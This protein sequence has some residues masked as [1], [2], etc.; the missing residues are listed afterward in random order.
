[1]IYLDTFSVNL[2]LQKEMCTYLVPNKKLRKYIMT[3]QIFK[4]EKLFHFA[5]IAILFI[6]SLNVH[7]QSWG[8]RGDAKTKV[9]VA[10]LKYQA[11]E[12]NLEAVGT[13]EAR[14]SVILF[15][16]V[17]ERVTLVDFE[18]G[19]FVEKDK[20]L[21]TLYNEREKV[22]LQRAKIQLKDTQR[23]YQRLVESRKKGAAS[24]SQVDVAQTAMALAEVAVKEADVALSERIVKAPFSGILGFTDVEVGD[25]ISQQT[26]ITT[27]DD[28]NELYIN[29]SAPEVA[30][31]ILNN[32]A[33]VFL[34]PWQDREVKIEASIAQVDSRISEQDRTIRVRALLNNE[35]DKY[36]PGMSFRVT[37]SI[38][39]QEYVAV[40]EASLLWSATGAY[41]W[42]MV[43]GKASRVDV[44]IQQRLLGTI[45]VQ[46]P[47]TAGAPLVVE[48]VQRLRGGQ[49]LEAM[50][51]N[52][53][54][55]NR[56]EEEK[57][58]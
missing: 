16:A 45:L 58:S 42:Q 57:A 39:G 6:A 53:S 23:E 22:A 3:L 40:P 19:Q 50:T 54:R 47:F 36:R 18:P 2:A 20:V 27:I 11:Q 21:L 14:K 32:E 33:K 52:A 37:L 46:G 15:P 34:T 31:D 25:R 43:E 56:N 51:S 44:Q 49:A 24:Q 5:S 41:V 35:S 4:R 48:G 26:Q 1:M 13:A 55:T 7:A 10:P 17:S 28:R 12:L 8:G 29:F 30:V 9:I 38:L